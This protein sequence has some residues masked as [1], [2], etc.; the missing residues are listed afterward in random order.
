MRGIGFALVGATVLAS[1]AMLATAISGVNAANE[2]IEIGLLRCTVAGGTSFIFGSSK[3]L[4]CVFERANGAAEAYVGNVSRFG[5]DV[6][7]TSESQLVWT[8][9]APAK[10][11]PPGALAG[12]YAG[13]SAEATAGVGLGANA[14]VGGGEHSIALQPVS[15]QTQQGVSIAAGVAELNLTAQ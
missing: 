12:T 15:V 4:G 5:I 1:A 9:L 13:V 3:D 8:V 2:R 14:L 10:D 7:T 6:G 11:F